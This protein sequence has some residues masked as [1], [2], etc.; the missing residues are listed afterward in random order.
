MSEEK[1]ENARASMRTRV[2]NENNRQEVVHL[3]HMKVKWRKTVHDENIR[4]IDA[5]LRERTLIV[6]RVGLMMLEC[7]TGAW[8][9]LDAMDRIARR[10]G[11][12]CTADIGLVSIS[13]TC[14]DGE[15]S[16]AVSLSIPTTGINTDKLQHLEKFIYEFR[17]R[18]HQM[19]LKEVHDWLDSISTLK[20]N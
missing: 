7:G 10:M 15:Q 12:T 13:Y 4:T 9:V 11:L 17:E 20:G 18:G 6:G 1:S 5:S 2:E 8:R 16:C 14:L 19:T 3:H